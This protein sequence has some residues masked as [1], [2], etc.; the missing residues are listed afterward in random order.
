MKG[1]LCNTT[2]KTNE[3]YRQVLKMRMYRFL[4]IGLVGTITLVT[5]LLAEFYWKLNVPEQMLGVYTGVGAGLLCISLIMLIKNKIL[6][7]DEEKLKQ[8]RINDADERIREISSRAFKTAAVIMLVVM[9]IAALVGGLFYP[10][11][12][13]LLLAIISVFAF[14]YVVAYSVYNKRM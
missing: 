11:L 12:V 10:V 3:E 1:L 4:C 7:G 8:S 2:A 5:A 13:K 6:L 14:A 9:Y